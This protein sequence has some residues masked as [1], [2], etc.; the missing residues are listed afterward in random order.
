MVPFP[1]KVPRDSIGQDISFKGRISDHGQLG[2]DKIPHLVMLNYLPVATGISSEVEAEGPPLLS[3]LLSRML[4][5]NNMR[6]HSLY[7]HESTFEDS[8]H[9]LLVTRV[10]A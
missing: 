4:S 5:V 8:G 6:V 7:L 3:I 10:D 2:V 1:E 9:F